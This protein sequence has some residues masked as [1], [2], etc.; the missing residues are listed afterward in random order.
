MFVLVVVAK[1]LTYL[2]TVILLDVFAIATLSPY[3]IA[4]MASTGSYQN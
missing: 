1:F 2:A 4:A 3:V